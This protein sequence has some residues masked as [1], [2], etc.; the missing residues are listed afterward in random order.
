MLDEG[1]D[2]YESSGATI[3]I[4]A[5]GKS[6]A[7]ASELTMA[8]NPEPESAYQLLESS[9]PDQEAP[10]GSIRAS[11]A[12]ETMI[13]N[14][15][16]ESTVPPSKSYMPEEEDASPMAPTQ[17]ISMSELPK[18]STA[19]KPPHQTQSRSP[20][21]PIPPP[22]PKQ[23]TIPPV[24][25]PP[26]LPTP[27]PQKYETY[28]PPPLEDSGVEELEMP[29]T[30]M[31]S[32]PQATT[33]VKNP[34]PPAPTPSPMHVPPPPKQSI[35][36][37]PYSLPSSPKPAGAAAPP[38]A[39]SALKMYWIG[40][41]AAALIIAVAGAFFLLPK[42][43]GPEKKEVVV[44]PP[45][46]KPIQVEP[47]PKEP[48]V[49]VPVITT[50]KI[51]VNSEPVG[52]TVLLNEEDKGITPV[53]LPEL[54]FGTYILK[55]RS[56]GYQEVQQEVVLS[57][58]SPEFTVGPVVLE[59]VV[60]TS[61]TLVV[62]SNPSGAFI[63]IQNKA[64]GVTPKTLANQKPGTIDILLRKD[65]YRDFSGS[66]KITAGKK[67]SFSGNLEEIKQVVEKPVEVPKPQEPTIATGSLV[68]ISDPDVVRPKPIKRV[69]AKYPEIAK[70]Q[71]VE[72]V[73]MLNVLIGETGK[74]LDVKVVQTASPLLE[75]AAID[76]VRQWVY[77]PATK[78]GVKVKVWV[79]VQMSF[80]SGR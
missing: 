66:V 29:A 24:N 47:K 1:P 33:G 75:Q 34:P 15:T 57:A 76:A 30:Q 44:T 68:Q 43:K 18:T 31:I 21:P 27:P 56:K 79:P 11:E 48:E 20:A 72:G 25:R 41:I 5:P 52:A 9:M 40:A 71:R 54:P 13:V 50:G 55:L 60:P 78:K 10:T 74:I 19:E 77:E 17:M 65:G 69:A 80:K 8:Y 45:E 61:G 14:T 36:D 53:E 28:N 7:A 26:V 49:V 35:P 39:K 63:I 70:K 73:V 12:S 2:Q 22:P 67:A 64:L 62:D 46:P 3:S 58:D 4:P 51:I 59:K 38:G 16:P 32:M 23:Q 37:S 42:L 6:P